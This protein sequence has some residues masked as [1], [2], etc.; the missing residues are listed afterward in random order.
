M[1]EQTAEEFA[2]RLALLPAVLVQATPDAV[3]EAGRVLEREAESNLRA[4]TGGDLRLSRVRSGR[5]ATVG[6]EI[7][8]VGAGGRAS[9]RVTG[10]GPVLLVEDDTRRHRQPF[11]Y[12][13]RY[14]I[15]AGQVTRRG[16]A[17]KRLR[18]KRKGFIYI[19]GVG[20][21]QSV[22]H[23]GTK[24]KRPIT[25]AFESD[26]DAAGDRGLDVFARAIRAHLGR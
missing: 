25:K 6:V 21:R 22:N 20:F 19:P 26:A 16:T 15:G 13:G 5:G 10:T 11:Q 3:A 14:T 12:S 4:A 17:A 9:A 18:A 1:A 7:N 2:R 24:G 8:V 23:P